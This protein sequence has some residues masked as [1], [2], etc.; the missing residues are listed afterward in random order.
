MSCRKGARVHGRTLVIVNPMARHGVTKSL[1]PLIVSLLDGHLDYDLVLTKHPGHATQMA[2]DAG[3][4]DQIVAAGGDGTVNEALNG[5]MRLPAADRPALTVLPTGSGNDYRRTLGISTDLPSAV[6]Q[7]LG[8]RRARMDVGIVNGMYFANSLAIGLDARV[9]AR[10]AEIKSTTGWSGLPLYLRALMYVLFRQFYAHRVTLS[11]D[12]EPASDRELL[13]VAITN[14][15]T[16]G[17]GFKITPSA[18]GDDGVFDVCI[19][20]KIGLAG[21]LWRLPF[22]VVGR[23][24]R[25]RP[26]SMSHHTSLRLESD[27]PIEAQADGEVM[28]S[29]TYDVRIEPLGVEVIVPERWA[30]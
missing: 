27:A 11:L 26:V 16:Y 12:G 29:T 24:T 28:L 1:V 15:P 30:T 9:T 17:G 14:G 18:V 5:I 4:Y 7:I 2:A 3:V 8:G 6:R 13:L 25:M 22:V 19:I 21:A 20:G 10:A 23:H